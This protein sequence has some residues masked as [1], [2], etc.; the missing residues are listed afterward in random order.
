MNQNTNNMNGDDAIIYDSG[1]NGISG[2]NQDY[3][4]Q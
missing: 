1:E 4:D 3:Q 2:E